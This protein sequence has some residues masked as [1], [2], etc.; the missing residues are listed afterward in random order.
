[1]GKT[2][3]TD[4]T[5]TAE[6]LEEARQKRLKEA[7]AEAQKDVDAN[8]KMHADAERKGAAEKPHQ[9]ETSEAGGIH[10]DRHAAEGA[11]VVVDHTGFDP[12]HPNSVDQEKLGMEPLKVKGGK[13]GAAI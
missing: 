11:T 1:M 9:Q 10:S 3:V 13:K 6:A 4:S 5:E 2:K 7:T 8:L 12:E